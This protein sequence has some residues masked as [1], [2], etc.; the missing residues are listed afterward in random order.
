[1][2][3]NFQ[4]EIFKHLMILKVIINI[5]IIIGWSNLFI[6]IKIVKNIKSH[7]MKKLNLII[8]VISVNNKVFQKIVY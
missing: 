8:W 5:I 1:M 7:K 3:F 4:I 6:I 2:K